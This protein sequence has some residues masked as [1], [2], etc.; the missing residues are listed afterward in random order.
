MKSVKRRSFLLRRGTLAVFG[1]VLLMWVSL[2]ASHLSATAGH[3]NHL[4]FN[5]A[6]AL[7]G[8]TLPAGSYTFEVINPTTSANTVQVTSRDRSKVH[9][10]GLTRRAHR[11]AGM[12]AN[13]AVRFGEASAGNPP[14]IRAWFPI[15][16]SSGHEFVY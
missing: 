7:P 13:Q 14:P 16:E 6:V 12:P 5:R 8:V 9:F 3:T 11:P 2:M 1:A 10:V 15:G 4:T